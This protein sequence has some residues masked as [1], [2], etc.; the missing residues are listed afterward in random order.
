MSA[1]PQG[2]REASLNKKNNGQK[3]LTLI[4]H[5]APAARPKKRHFRLVTGFIII[6]L[7]P[8]VLAAGYLYTRA[9]DQYASTVGFSVR[10]ADTA[11][12]LELLGGISDL[13]GSS[14]SDADILYAFLQSQELVEKLD[15]TLDLRAIFAGSASDPIFSFGSEGSVEDLVSF[16]KRMTNVGYDAGTGLIEFRALA[17]SPDAAKMVATGAFRESSEMINRLS[18]IAREDATLYATEELDASSVRLAEAREALTSF[19]ISAQIVDP[20]ADIQSQMGLLGS[21]QGQLAEA[22]I[23]VNVL[24]EVTGPSD[25]RVTLAERRIEIIR[26]QIAQERAKFG[27]VGGDAQNAPYAE[28]VAEFERLKLEREFAEQAYATA[29]ASY[30]AA[31]AE[32]RRQ[33]RYLAAYLQ[34]TLAQTAEY[35][36]RI[37]LLISLGLLLLVGWSIAVMIY[38]SIRDRG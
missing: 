32:A 18:A 27:I 30:H 2:E 31:R 36:K 22:L 15:E 14:S 9:L 20:D 19:R 11:S 3:R 38:Y 17:F 25:N 37:E 7:V 5:V 1:V 28:I 33:S 24:R 26:E 10:S 8:V 23:A 29:L 6:V 16:W 13:S 12:P 4:P 21:L 34:P 35:P